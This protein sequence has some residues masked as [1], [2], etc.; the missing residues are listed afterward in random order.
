[1]DT[2]TDYTLKI[3]LDEDPMNPRDW[4]NLGK[5]VMFHNRYNLPN[6]CDE[7]YSV[8]SAQEFLAENHKD[9]FW[10]PIYMLDHSGVSVSTRSF[11]DPWDS[12]CVGFIFVEKSDVRKEWKVQ[13]ISQKIKDIVSKNLI[14]EV[15]TYD[16]YLTGNVYGYQI[17]DSDGNCVDSCYGFY[18]KKWA[19][20]EGNSAL[21]YHKSNPE[22]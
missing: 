10:F 2:K 18:G 8:E 5:M 17:L 15:E 16:D 13:R 6:E 21:E 11:N 9:I 7:T 3:V 12:G 1:M 14:G 22:N 19:E 20:E 4:D